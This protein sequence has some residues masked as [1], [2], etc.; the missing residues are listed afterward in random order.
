MSPLYKRHS[1]DSDDS[2]DEEDEPVKKKQCG[3]IKPSGA[4]F[5]KWLDD[6]GDDLA[7]GKKV[8]SSTSM[9]RNKGY[10]K[11]E[12]FYRSL[13]KHFGIHQKT[14][15]QM[16]SNYLNF[17]HISE[18]DPFNQAVLKDIQ[19]LI[20]EEGY[21]Y[22][23]AVRE[24]LGKQKYRGAIDKMCR[25]YIMAATNDYV[26][27]D[28]Q[29]RQDVESP[30]DTDD[31]ADDDDNDGSSDDGDDDDGSSDADDA[32]ESADGEEK[33]SSDEDKTQGD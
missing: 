13:C 11:E 19:K 30:D 6:S 2:A 22:G 24:V 26:D 31:S 1:D 10:A 12:A 27:S 5:K 16:Y 21:S 25:E 18:K 15:T 14:L 9:Y 17:S 4:M 33:G 8:K 7:D 23:D 3:E 32:S 20:K 29:V 28:H